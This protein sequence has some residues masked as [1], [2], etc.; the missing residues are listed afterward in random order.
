MMNLG[1][2]FPDE[3]DQSEESKDAGQEDPYVAYGLSIFLGSNET[4]CGGEGNCR[5]SVV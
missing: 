3:I 5:S 1:R 4:V 2:E